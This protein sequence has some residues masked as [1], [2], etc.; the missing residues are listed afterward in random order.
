MKNLPRPNDLFYPNAHQGREAPANSG[1]R[2]GFPPQLHFKGTPTKIYS[3]TQMAAPYP[4]IYQSLPQVTVPYVHDQTPNGKTL[5][6]PLPKLQLPQDPFHLFNA[7]HHEIEA[8]PA[9]V[10]HSYLNVSYRMQNRPRSPQTLLDLKGDAMNS[11][12]MIKNISAFASQN[13][14][15]QLTPFGEAKMPPSRRLVEKGVRFVQKAYA[16]SGIAPWT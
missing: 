9:L 16:K 6:L 1:V 8:T 2:H 13:R 12:P 14:Q 15:E 11:T 5:V 7:R 3:D 4:R 10:W